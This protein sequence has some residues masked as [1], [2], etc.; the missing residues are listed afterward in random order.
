[1]CIYIY[2][3]IIFN[4]FQDIVK[5]DDCRILESTSQ[6]L[7]ITEDQLMACQRV[8]PNSSIDHEL[9]TWVEKLVLKAILDV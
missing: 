3:I 2:K 7:T 8:P 9:M 6:I 1:M 4:C 5:P